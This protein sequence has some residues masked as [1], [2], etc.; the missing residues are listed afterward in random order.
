MTAILSHPLR[1]LQVNTTDVQGGAAKVARTLH[2]L[3]LA[4]GHD[5]YLTV[6][7]ARQPDGRIRTLDN[8]RKN[9]PVWLARGV[10]QR[11][12][13]WQDISYPGSHRLPALS[14]RAGTSST[15]TTYTASISTWAH[16]RPWRAARR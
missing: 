9:H 13:G 3:Y 15:R 10:F 2:D 8:R 7:V 4:G 12:F 1:I 11:A 6:S 16:S 14:L 5:A